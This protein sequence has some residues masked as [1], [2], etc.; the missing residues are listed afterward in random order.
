M[1]KGVRKALIAFNIDPHAIT[2]SGDISHM[3]GGKRPSTTKLREALKEFGVGSELLDDAMQ[4]LL[5][6]EQH[7]FSVEGWPKDTVDLMRANYTMGEKELKRALGV[8]TLLK[9]TITCKSTSTLIYAG[10]TFPAIGLYCVAQRRKGLPRL[11]RGH[12]VRGRLQHHH[13]LIPGHR[14]HRC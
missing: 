10:R 1:S 7:C 4:E 2:D 11:A 5:S 14:V 6:I 3:L 13:A 12:R 8:K 9:G